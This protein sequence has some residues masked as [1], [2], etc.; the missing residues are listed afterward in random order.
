MND[1]VSEIQKKLVTLI[2]IKYE[3]KEKTDKL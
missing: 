1:R 3:I 2:H